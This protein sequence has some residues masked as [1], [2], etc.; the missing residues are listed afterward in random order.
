[1]K[2]QKQFGKTTKMGG[3][4]SLSFKIYYAASVSRLRGICGETDT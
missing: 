2:Y 1:M 3:I 4:F